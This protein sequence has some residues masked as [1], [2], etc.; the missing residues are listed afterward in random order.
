[1]DRQA[2]RPVSLSCQR[3]ATVLDLLYAGFI[4][5]HFW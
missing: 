4:K 1:M 5:R 2:R 3:A